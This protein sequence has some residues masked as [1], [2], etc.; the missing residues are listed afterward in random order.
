MYIAARRETSARKKSNQQLTARASA[1]SPRGFEIAP[2]K[3][4]PRA[5]LYF[6]GCLLRLSATLA[7][8]LLLL[9]LPSPHSPLSQHRVRLDFLKTTQPDSRR[10]PPQ[11]LS[12]IFLLLREQRVVALRMLLGIWGGDEF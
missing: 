4:L 9:L 10:T 8:C 2:W 3:V 12:I 7:A 1:N 6:P 5:V 11:R